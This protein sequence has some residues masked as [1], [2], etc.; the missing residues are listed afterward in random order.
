MLRD[1]KKKLGGNM[2]AARRRVGLT[3]AEVARGVNMATEVYGR[4]ERGLM[5][6]SLP[7]LVRL[8]LTL[9]AEPSELLGRVDTVPA[10][11]QPRSSPSSSSWWTRLISGAYSGGSRAP[12]APISSCWQRWP[13]PP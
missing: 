10:A 1:L 3:Q 8:G 12:D 2:L 13:M 4:M 7:T 5:L 9:E 6:P 11:A